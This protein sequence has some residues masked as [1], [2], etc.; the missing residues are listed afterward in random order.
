MTINF[1]ALVEINAFLN[2][3]CNYFYK[4]IAL[5]KFITP[6]VKSNKLK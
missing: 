1:K 4:T 3:K 5:K 6:Y 2:E